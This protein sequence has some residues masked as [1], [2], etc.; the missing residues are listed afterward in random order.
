MSAL[1]EIRPARPEDVDAILEVINEAAEVY[2][3]VIA[4][5]R[6]R[7]P[8]MPRAELLDELAA[9]VRFWVVERSS[10]VVVAVMGLQHVHDVALIRHAYT[11]PRD[12][13]T[14]LGSALLEHVRGQSDRRMLVGT[15]RAATWAVRFYQRHGFRLLEEPEAARSL[16]RYWTV[17][18][19]QIEESVVLAADRREA[20]RGAGSEPAG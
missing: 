10:G 1:G 11:R 17:P 8:Y 3:G 4:N 12:Q 7:E 18:E 15:W 2:R 13:R 19:R 14:G 6:W 9:G 20:A 5:D 16:R